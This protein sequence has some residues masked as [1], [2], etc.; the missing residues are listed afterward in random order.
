MPDFGQRIISKT[1]VE[2]CHRDKFMQVRNLFNSPIRY[3]DLPSAASHTGLR[4]TRKFISSM[5]SLRETRTTIGQPEA[6]YDSIE[7][8][9]SE[10]AVVIT[11]T[12]TDGFLLLANRILACQ[13][14]YKKFKY[15]KNRKHD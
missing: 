12:R 11:F 1:F 15:K 6:F 2:S 9:W 13:I 7:L 3:F 5:R 14:Q 4:A 8:S 10:F